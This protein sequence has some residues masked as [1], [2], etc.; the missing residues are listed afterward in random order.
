MTGAM[1]PMG[2]PLG[3]V[4][5]VD[6]ASFCTRHAPGSCLEMIVAVNGCMADLTF[7]ELCGQGPERR[8]PAWPGNATAKL[9]ELGCPRCFLERRRQ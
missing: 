7:Q 5:S 6:P 2:P 3:P 1:V 9:A 4:V 8:N